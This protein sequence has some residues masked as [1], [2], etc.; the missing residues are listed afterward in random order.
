ML[1]AAVAT[2]VRP[3]IEE[4]AL[5]AEQVDDRDVVG[6][7]PRALTLLSRA[8]E[9]PGVHF[10]VTLPAPSPANKRTRIDPE[11]ELAL[12]L[13]EQQSA[14]HSNVTLAVGERW[15]VVPQA[16]PCAEPKAVSR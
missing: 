8:H 3:V 4:V 11:V 6:W 1:V 13:I 5:V 12:K 7:L 15:G 9:L 2:D 16:G 10:C 14:G